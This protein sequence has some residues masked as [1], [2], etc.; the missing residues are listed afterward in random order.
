MSEAISDDDE[1]QTDGSVYSALTSFLREQGLIFREEAERQ[2]V[3]FEYATKQ[4]VW[5]TFGVAFEDD[6]QVAIYGVVPFAI[7]AERR[8]AALELLARINYGQVIGNFEMDLEDGEVRFK[9]SLDFDGA[10]LT[11]NLLR[12]LFAAN[13]SVMEHYLP[14][15]TAVCV[16]DRPVAHALAAV[17]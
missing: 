11:Y 14:V 6:Q 4:A 9:T 10:E 8:A 16:E 2:R 13:V 12:Q 7:R 17:S 3:H 1:P 5:T 15:I